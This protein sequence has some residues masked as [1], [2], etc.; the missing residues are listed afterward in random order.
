PE[1]NDMVEYF[2]E[3]L[4]GVAT[5]KL[6]W[7]QSYGSRCAKP[8]IIV[9]D[10]SRRAPMTV[11][12]ASFAQSLTTRP[13]KGMLTGPVTILQWSF[14]REDVPRSETS[15]QIGLAL[16]DEVADLES[17]GIRVIQIDEP[18]FK[19]AMPLRREEQAAYLRWAIDSFKLAAGGAGRGV[20]IHTHMCYSEFGDIIEA[21]AELDADVLY[22]EAARSGMDLLR[23]FADVG[24]PNEVGP[25]VY[26]IHSPLVPSQAEMAERLRAAAKVIPLERLWANPDCGL[27]TRGWAEVEPSLRNLWGQPGRSRPSCSRSWPASGAQSGEGGVRAG[28]DRASLASAVGGAGARSCGP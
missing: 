27:K 6:G 2:A 22:I 16:R 15:F 18:A 10:V 25:G 4:D 8:P 1:R 14:P 12:W 28:G 20:Q 5:T 19:E 3:Q 26:D 21:I 11:R 13:V 9:G 24:Y 23:A 17:A 7:V